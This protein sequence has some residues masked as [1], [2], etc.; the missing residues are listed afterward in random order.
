MNYFFRSKG[1]AILSFLS[2]FAWTPDTAV[3]CSGGATEGTLIYSGGNL[4]VRRAASWYT[5]VGT[6]IGG[7]CTNGTI[8]YISGKL[9]YCDGSA[10]RHVTRGNHETW[11]S[12]AGNT[13]TG[14]NAGEYYYSTSGDIYSYCDGTDWHQFN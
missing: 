14:A 6:A 7:A 11:G 5:I 1:L 9:R 2:L 8:Q 10:W 12:D 4:C 13:C 3:A